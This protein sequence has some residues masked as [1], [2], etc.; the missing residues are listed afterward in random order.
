M[1]VF[2]LTAKIGLDKSEY[3]SGLAGAKVSMSNLAQGVGNGLKTVAK[4]GGAAIAAGAA[5]VAALTKM[6]VEGYAQ[7]E[8]L[9]GGVETLFKTSQDIVMG[10]AE[11]AYKTAGMSANAYMETVTSF[12]A[13]L[14][15]SLDG[16]TA[17]AAEV[18]NMA[19]TDMSDNANKMGTSMEMIQNAYNG[20]AKSNFTMLDNLK[21][22]YGGTKEEMERLIADANKVKEANGEMADL[23]IDS[24]ADVAEAIHIIQSEMG[25]TGTTAKEAASTIEGSLSMMKGAWENLVVGMADEN[26]NMEVLMG[27]FV[28][29][30]KTAA[31]NLLPRIEQTLKGI[32]T[33]VEQMAPVIAEALP[34]MIVAVLPSLLS[35]GV[36]LITAIAK[37]LITAA[38]ALYEAL[39][40]ALFIVFTQVFGATEEKANGFV[41]ALDATFRTLADAVATVCG[42]IGEF[43]EWL[44]SGSTGAEVFKGVIIAITAAIIAYQTATAIGTAVTTGL[45]TAQTLLNAVMAANPIGL[46]IAAVAA[47]VAG[48]VLLWNNCDGF[49]QFWIDLWDGIKNAAQ[50]VADWFVQAWTDVVNWF[51]QAVQDIG[52]FFTN[53][54][55]SITAGVSAVSQF[56]VDL[57]NGI[58]TGMQ[59]AWDW[60]VN[61]FSTVSGWIY[62]NV[63]AP[64]A[65]FFVELWEGIVNAYHTVIDPWI[66]IFRRLAVIVNEEIVTPIKEF[67]VEL[68]DSIVSGLQTAWDWCVNLLSSVAS[69]IY[70][71]IV[72]PIAEFFG[73]LW[74]D[75]K[76]SASDLWNS[77]KG[78]AISAWNGIK[79]AFSV[80]ADWFDDTVVQP[81]ASFFTGMWNGL[82]SG[83]SS[84]WTGIKSVFS[85]VS[86]WFKNTFST[87]W[88]KVKDVFSTGGKVF[89]GVKDGI[90]T[91]FKTV[92]NAIIGGINK[93]ISIPFE[94]ING[95]LKKINSIEILGVSPFT[96]VHTFSVPQI[97]KL[98]TGLNYVPYDE[99]PAFLHRG[100]AV[101]T[102]AQARAWRNGQAQPAMAG[103]GAGGITINQYI[104]TVP[105]T[106]VE[107]ANATEAYFEQARWTL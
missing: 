42:K 64:V 57:W 103:A 81:V 100:E 19:I 83:A 61:L 23:S 20:F 22:G 97:P 24:F 58:T 106:P 54:W 1:D 73:E 80:A 14:I 89:D 63:I 72:A 95:I 71:N 44:N 84:A 86:N 88:Q 77:V 94:A 10:Y 104:Q 34:Q 39:M 36:Q 52:N 27:N 93:V 3:E 69:W 11:N 65:Q 68:W 78:A 8:Q 7:Y 33:L 51:S 12:S 31:G 43:I 87:A 45:A 21:L 55:T 29:S 47:L 30:A 4:I 91:A 38:P 107:F 70:D 9:V 28:E 49:R 13:S 17:K 66:E 76:D 2:E 102:A 96:W 75:L 56:F 105:Q 98:S 35:A 32:G 92:V 90:V 25:I 46:V 62:E 26:A 101:L 18:G 15:Q 79:G 99:Y 82:T 67:F 41:G 37:G 60:C 59:T 48:F 6:G 5:G 85:S 74:G 40:E 16:D 53:L 50:A